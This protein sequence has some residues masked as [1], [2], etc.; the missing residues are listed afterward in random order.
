M[1][2]G[3]S[4]GGT[5]GAGGLQAMQDAAAKLNAMQAA[6]GV[7][8]GLGL[9]PVPGGLGSLVNPRGF[10]YDA[11]SRVEI[12]KDDGTVVPGPIL[13]QRYWRVLP[14]GGKTLVSLNGQAWP[15]GMPLEALPRHGCCAGPAPVSGCNCGV[16]AMKVGQPMGTAGITQPATIPIKGKVALWGRVIEHETGYR[17]QY[18]YPY[19]IINHRPMPGFPSTNADLL[20]LIAEG[21]GIPV[22]NA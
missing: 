19:A 5:V 15:M 11:P 21:Y 7:L 17:A 10:M 14:G 9:N 12:L 18:A 13:A 4:V 20:S 1:R 3:P 16:Y 8:A 6:Q 2:L 22:I